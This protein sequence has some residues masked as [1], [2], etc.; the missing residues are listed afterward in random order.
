MKFGELLMEMG[1][2]N[3]E[4]LDIALKEQEYSLQT[5]SYTEPIGNIL[6]RNGVINEKQHI[7]ALLQYFRNIAKDTKEPLYV[8]ET[9][10]VAIKALGSK[11]EASKLSQESKIALIHKISEYEENISQLE[12]TNT[13]Q[14]EKMVNDLI[15]RIKYIKKDIEK[16]A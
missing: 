6:L 11:S 14:K 10:K 9:A 7:K 5:V 16:Y 1:F 2:I 4:Q 12:H 3:N 8:K 13:P 15:K